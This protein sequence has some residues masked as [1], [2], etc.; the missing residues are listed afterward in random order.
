MGGV[1][2]GGWGLLAQPGAGAAAA[3]AAQQPLIY[4]LA[5]YL[6]S[7]PSAAPAAPPG[8][9]APPP[10]PGVHVHREEGATVAAGTGEPA[11]S[12]ATGLRFAGKKR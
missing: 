2:L 3:A 10:P 12:M 11:V 6:V 1:L 9:S 8:P 4:Y 5:A 7:G